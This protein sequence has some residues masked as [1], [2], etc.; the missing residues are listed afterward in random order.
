MQVKE[1]ERSL[2][3]ARAVVKVFPGTVALDGV[4]LELR[5]GEVHAVVGENGAGKSTLMKILSGAYRLSSGQILIDGEEVSLNSIEDAQ[6]HGIAMLYQELSNVPKLSV[7]ENI[8]LGLLPRG[9]LGLVDFR[10]LFSRTQGYFET[11]KVDIDPKTI[12]SRLT[13]AEKQFV[14]IIRVITAKNARIVIM[15]EPTSSLTKSETERL[16]TI[17]RELKKRGT[18][19][20]YIS[21]RLDE[22]QEIADRLSVFRDGKNVG[23]LER[24]QFDERRIITLML[25]QALMRLEKEAA[26]SR[27]PREK[28]LFEVRSLVIPRRVAG[29]SMKLY[30]GEIL[31][32]AGLMGSGKDELVKCLFG[33]WPALS[34]EVRFRGKAVD[35]RSPKQAIDHGIVYLPEERKLTSLFLELSVK[36]NISPLWLFNV[37]KRFFLQAKAED[38]L[39]GSVI[40]QLNIKTSSPQEQIVNLSGGNQQKAVFSRLIALKPTLMILNDPTRGVDVGSKEE[41]YRIIRRLVSGGTSIILVS[42]EIDEICYLADRV[43]VL[44]KGEICGQFADAEVTQEN[45]LTCAIRAK[46]HEK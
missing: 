12:L 41:I 10:T 17:I 2:L 7:A 31:A 38:E 33:L 32:I 40:A 30:E 14:E 9:P 16:F 36:Y 39:V 25:G 5:R 3:E 44:S 19:I 37:R 11:Y 6:Q 8:F 4:N 18:T 26:K 13:L 34:K 22:V 23:T 45:V 24:G 43:I 35:I 1:S 27:L 21:H 20:V 42:S 15:D 28:V 46:L 29:F